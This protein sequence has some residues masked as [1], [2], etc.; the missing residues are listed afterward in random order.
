MAM[1]VRVQTF[2]FSPPSPQANEGIPLE[3]MAIF[4]LTDSSAFIWC[5]LAH[6]KCILNLSGYLFHY[7]EHLIV[8]TDRPQS[9]ITL[10]NIQQELWFREQ[11]NSIPRSLL[12]EM[13]NRLELADSCL[14][15]L[16]C[17]QTIP[18]QSDTK[19]H[20]SSRGH[21]FKIFFWPLYNV[22]RP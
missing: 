2:C 17:S 16:L 18:I 6:C 3:F 7:I 4:T 22:A 15:S 1:R 19:C 11:F 12:L 10:T 5:T 13:Y 8:M 21:T 14:S 9:N 20:I